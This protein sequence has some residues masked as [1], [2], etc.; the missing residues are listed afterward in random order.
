MINTKL[1]EVLSREL[2]E[3]QTSNNPE[4]IERLN[5]AS[6]ILDKKFISSD[7]LVDYLK[8]TDENGSL[9]SAAMQLFSKYI[10]T[11]RA[12]S[13]EIGIYP[14]LMS[15]FVQIEE[16]IDLGEFPELKNPQIG[17]AHV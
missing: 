6:I 5:L 1:Y 15:L 14:F 12:S 13:D 2:V 16:I 3:A 4:L 10:F 9:T 17:R 7:C 8:W 11:K